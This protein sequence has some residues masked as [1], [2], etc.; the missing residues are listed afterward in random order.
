MALS[1]ELLLKIYYN[2]VSSPTI[3]RDFLGSHSKHRTRLACS[4]LPEYRY[5][6]YFT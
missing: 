1:V 6:L 5:A 4:W 3:K 2:H